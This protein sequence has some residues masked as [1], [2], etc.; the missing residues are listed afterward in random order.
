MSTKQINFTIV[1]AESGAGGDRTYANFCA[2]AHSPFD[3]TVTFCDVRPLTAA[4]IAEAERTQTVKAPVVARI[5]LPFAVI[6]GLVNALQEQLRA[7]Q[8]GQA[9]GGAPPWP[10]PGPLH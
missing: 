7:M 10:E 4:D 8:A 1:P 6:P 2:V 5:A 9:D 3:L